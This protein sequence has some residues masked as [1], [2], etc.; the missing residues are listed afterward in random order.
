MRRLTNLM[1]LL[2]IAMLQTVPAF[3][4]VGRISR[5]SYG[6]GTQEKRKPATEE[7]EQ[8]IELSGRLVTLYF[9]VNDQ[10]GAY[11][12]DLKREELQVLED[13]KPQ[14]LFS[15]FRQ[16]DLPLT[17]AVLIDV[18][19]SEQMT[20]PFLKSAAAEFFQSFIRPDKDAVSI[21]QFR[22]ETILLQDFT[23][24]LERLERGLERVR[25]TRPI[26]RDSSSRFG[27]TSMYDAVF[28]TCEESLGRQ[29]GRR[30]I[31]L[32]T[33]GEDTTSSYKSHEAINQALRSEVTI[34]AIGIGDRAFGGVNEGALK[35]LTGETGGRAYF[36]RKDGDLA[37]AFKQ[38]ENE[39]RT[40]YYLA[41]YP[42]NA[43][44]D[45]TYRSIQVLIPGREKIRINHRRGYYAP[46]AKS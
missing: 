9:N 14:E 35:R 5:R 17:I 2:A 34:Y 11:I 38:I 42:S 39:L 23:S 3:S 41:Y 19:G 44:R 18:S 4:I 21:S 29:A 24:T 15:F 1:A 16:T 40:Q 36:P 37:R 13:K 22:D 27:G 10:R 30:T 12:T 8:P 33:D 20:L 43:A 28:V 46:E 25:Y 45:G 31:I 32:L 26:G 6:V 7:Q